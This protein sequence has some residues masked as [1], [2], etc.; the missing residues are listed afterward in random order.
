MRKEP[1]KCFR[2]NITSCTN[3]HLIFGED[4]REL[5]TDSQIRADPTRV[6]IIW[7]RKSVALLFSEQGWK[8]VKLLG[9]ARQQVCGLVPFPEAKLQ[10][11]MTLLSCWI[12]KILLLRHDLCANARIKCRGL[13]SARRK[14]YILSVLRKKIQQSGH[15][16]CDANVFGPWNDQKLN[17]GIYMS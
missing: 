2:N 15:P 9:L 5:C 4:S 16:G 7:P 1:L 12:R 11:H 17:L 14:H 3:F 8:F 10:I 13:A 6:I